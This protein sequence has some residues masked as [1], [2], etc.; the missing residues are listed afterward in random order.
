M[1]DSPLNVLTRYLS[2]EFENP[3]QAAANP[4]WF[5]H[6]RLWQRPVPSL[7]QQNLTTLFLEQANVISGQPPYRQRILQLSADPENADALAGEYFALSDPLKFR[8]GGDRPDVL[9]SMSKSDLVALPNSEALIETYPSTGGYRFKAS[10]PEG[11]LCSFEY[12]GQTK[13]VHLG[14]E[15]APRDGTLLLKTYDK[16]IDPS[17]GQGLWGA[18]MGP[19]EMVKQ[20]AY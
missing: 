15:I 1:S 9:S 19:F 6:L 5:V 10:L 14:F 18:L 2:G 8:G 4:T 11:K 7:C 12:A 20:T 13:Y 17:T 16:G 3:D